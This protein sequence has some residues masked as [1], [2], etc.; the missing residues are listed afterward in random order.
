MKTRTLAFT[1][2]LHTIGKPFSRVLSVH[3]RV[4]VGFRC[5]EFNASMV[6]L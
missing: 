2:G 6:D 4:Q 3:V 5:C 1:F